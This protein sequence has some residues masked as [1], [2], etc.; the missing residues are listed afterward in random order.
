MLWTTA[1]IQIWK[2]TAEGKS[3]PKKTWVLQNNKANHA[4]Q[5]KKT[6][7]VLAPPSISKNE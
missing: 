4:M 3:I 6:G 7:N 2:N 5:K 1:D